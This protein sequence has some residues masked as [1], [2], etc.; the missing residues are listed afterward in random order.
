MIL[1]VSFSCDGATVSLVRRYKQSKQRELH[2]LSDAAVLPLFAAT[3][4]AGGQE[5]RR[6]PPEFDF[7][8]HSP[9]SDLARTALGKSS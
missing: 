5:L 6:E 7:M 4:R 1:E 9:G 8:Y 3:K 2:L